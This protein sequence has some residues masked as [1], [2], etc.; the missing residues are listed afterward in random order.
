MPYNRS[1]VKGVY[2]EGRGIKTWG[3]DRDRQEDM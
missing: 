3:K 1:G 2:W